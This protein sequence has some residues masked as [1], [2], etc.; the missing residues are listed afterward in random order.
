M[1]NKINNQQSM[2]LSIEQAESYLRECGIY[3]HTN[4]CLIVTTQD[5]EGVYLDKED[6]QNLISCLNKYIQD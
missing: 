3:P 5:S 6:I 2:E 4:K 1:E